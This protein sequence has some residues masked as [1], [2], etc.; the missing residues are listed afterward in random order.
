MSGS[1]FDIAINFVQQGSIIKDILI[2]IGGAFATLLAGFG[3]VLLG[4]KITKDQRREEIF[5]IELNKLNFIY[6]FLEEYIS[7]LNQ[8]IQEFIKT[9]KYVCEKKDVQNELLAATSGYFSQ[10]IDIQT[11]DYSF[12]A[13][14]NPALLTTLHMLI[15]WS[16]AL[17]GIIQEHDSFIKNKADSEVIP[18]EKYEEYMNIYLARISDLV[19]SMYTDATNTLFLACLL[20]KHIYILLT[21]K[22]KYEIKNYKEDRI[23]NIIENY[24]NN[25]KIY[26]E[27]TKGLDES[28]ESR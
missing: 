1:L 21:Q 27:W 4:A 13:E 10:D 7:N 5:N 9:K 15:K 6:I 17:Q 20:Y 23:N 3:G 22:Y 16:N 26:S 18:K 24:K 2:P 28:W 19:T 8:F 25:S 12:I 11:K 14:K